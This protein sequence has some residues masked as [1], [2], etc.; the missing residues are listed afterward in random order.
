MGLSGLA[1]ASGWPHLAREAPSAEGTRQGRG[2][3]AGCFELPPCVLQTFHM[4]LS[5]SW[6]SCCL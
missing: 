4:S 1:G 3:S 6:E 2:C 5:I